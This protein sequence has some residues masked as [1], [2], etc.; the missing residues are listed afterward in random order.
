MWA[1]TMLGHSS[2]FPILVHCS[3]RSVNS[4]RRHS[5]RGQ[6]RCEQTP[7]Y[8]RG[9]SASY[10]PGDWF[11]MGEWDREDTRSILAR[12]QLG[13]RA[14]VIDLK[15]HALYHLRPSEGGQQFDRPRFDH[16]WPASISD[17]T[18]ERPHAALNSIL[19]GTAAQKTISVADDGI[20]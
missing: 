14:A 7:R 17:R 16:I 8:L 13:I 15:I 12:T 3:T 2:P 1:Y 6:I 10:D 5:N 18:R 9:M 19:S 11:V 20:S 4:V